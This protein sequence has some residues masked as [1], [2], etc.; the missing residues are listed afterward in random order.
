[1]K[2]V[3]ALRRYGHQIVIGNI[4]ST[5]KNVVEFFIRCSRVTE[6]KGNSESLPMASSTDSLL[7]SDSIDIKKLTMELSEEQQANKV[8][9]ERLIVPELIELHTKHIGSSV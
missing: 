4:L 7:D 5:R 2:A 1:M 6:P 9:I 8:E 3:Q